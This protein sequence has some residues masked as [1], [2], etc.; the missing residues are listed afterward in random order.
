M[1]LVVFYPK[2]KVLTSISLNDILDKKVE[3]LHPVVNEI[4]KGDRRDE[5]IQMQRVQL[6]L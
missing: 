1:P 3:K 4:T 5:E 2:K 6:R